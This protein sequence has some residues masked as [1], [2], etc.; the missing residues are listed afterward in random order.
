MITQEKHQMREQ[1]HVKPAPSNDE[2]ERALK[3]IA[4]KGGL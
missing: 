1:N 2:K 4:T 3:R